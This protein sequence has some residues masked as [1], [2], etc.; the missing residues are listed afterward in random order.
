MTSV[1]AGFHDD[2][3]CFYENSDLF[4][5]SSDHEGFGNV[6]VEALSFGLPVV[7]TDCPSGPAEILGNGRWEVL[8]LWETSMH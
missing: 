2:P 6:L 4:V 5:L 1:F 3:T 7:S 8:Y